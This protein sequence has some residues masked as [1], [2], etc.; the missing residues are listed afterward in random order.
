VTKVGALF[1]SV[2][3]LQNAKEADSF[4]MNTVEEIPYD[5]YNFQFCEEFFAH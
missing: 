4:S 5:L 3:F 1:S 2:H